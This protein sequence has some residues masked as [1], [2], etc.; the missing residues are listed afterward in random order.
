MPNVIDCGTGG[1]MAPIITTSFGYDYVQNK[2]K[3]IHTGEPDW[4]RKKHKEVITKWRPG[5]QNKG[6]LFLLMNKK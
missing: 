2:Y 1:T 5:E 6:D 4:L 3:W